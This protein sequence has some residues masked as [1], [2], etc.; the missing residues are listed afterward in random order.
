MRLQPELVAQIDAMADHRDLTRTGM[1]ER[2]IEVAIAAR[3]RACK[4]THRQNARCGECG[5]L[6]TPAETPDNL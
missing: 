4:V 1:A 6:T 2:T 5:L 3:Q